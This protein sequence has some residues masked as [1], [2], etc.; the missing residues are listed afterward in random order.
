MSR[1]QALQTFSQDLSISHSQIFCYLTC[2]LKYHFQYVKQKPPERI[3]INLPFG[4]AIHSA[5][6]TAY[7]SIKNTGQVEPVSTIIQVFEECLN[8]DLDAATVPIVY[9]KASPDRSG[10]LALG[11]AML[12]VFHESIVRTVQTAQ[13]V[14]V[15]LAVVSQALH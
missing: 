4:R 14:E 5:M 13:I 2:S 6:E 1:N 8:L 15:E 11:K 12:E 7:R 3:S 10:A 9:K